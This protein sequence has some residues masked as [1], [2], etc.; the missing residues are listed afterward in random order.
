MEKRGNI[1]TENVIFILLTL[2]FFAVLIT[3]IF[4]RTSGAAILEEELA[5]QVALIVDSAKPGMVIKINV[6]DAIQ[7]AKK[8]KYSQNI[9]TINGN[10]VTIK[11][12]E[13]G[14]YSYSFFN[15]VK[16]NVFPDTSQSEI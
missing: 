10:L 7:E 14:G 4:S 15:D 6:E 12:R 16:A 9:I 3:F 5:K 2:I 1:L 8:E 13:H 11:F